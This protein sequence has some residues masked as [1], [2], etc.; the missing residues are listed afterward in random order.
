MAA[1]HWKPNAEDLEYRP[2]DLLLLRYGRGTGKLLSPA[3]DLIDLCWHRDAVAFQT[4][5]EAQRFIQEN[6]ISQGP[7]HVGSSHSCSTG[8]QRP[9][10]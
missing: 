8:G 9:R 5:E 7:R 3:G 2:H 6:R 4:K 1:E 10:P